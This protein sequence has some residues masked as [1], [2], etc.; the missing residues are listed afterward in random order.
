MARLLLVENPA[1]GGGAAADAIQ[2]GVEQL[3]LQGH[4]VEVLTTTGPGVARIAVALR[5]SEFDRVGACGGDGTLSEVADGMRL[6]GSGRPLVLVP[7]GT[8]NDLISALMPGMT[9]ADALRLAFSGA[10]APLD[11]GFAGSL[12]FLNGV[13]AGFAAEASESASAELKAWLGPLAYLASGLAHLGS[14]SA[15]HAI[16]EGGGKTW[17]GDAL[18][19]AVANGPTMGG[20]SRVAPHASVSDGLLDLVVLPSLGPV[21]L[22]GALRAL[23]VGTEHPDLVYWQAPSFQFAADREVALNR[24]GEAFRAS[25]LLF[26][27]EAGALSYVHHPAFRGEGDG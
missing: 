10:V 26:R 6:S 25:S 15:F 11:L 22:P 20:G 13:S 7:S 24:D 3:R 9:P 4:Q 12:P 2:A 8:A 5:S 17:E 21:R 14:A 19:F 18:F 23:R 1:A 27:V 16:F